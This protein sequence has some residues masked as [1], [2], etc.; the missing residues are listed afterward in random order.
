MLCIPYGINQLF[1][2]GFEIGKFCVITF[3]YIWIKYVKAT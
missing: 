3:L 2:L 1:I